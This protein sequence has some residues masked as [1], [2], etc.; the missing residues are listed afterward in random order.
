M[1]VVR[2]VEAEHVSVVG[3]KRGAWDN[4][5]ENVFTS[6]DREGLV[7]FQITGTSVVV[8]AETCDVT[9]CV[10]AGAGI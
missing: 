1:I 4:S 9:G 6:L 7:S 10:V 8:S 2:W 3:G 5:F